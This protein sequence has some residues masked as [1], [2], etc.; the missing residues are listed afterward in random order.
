LRPGLW[1]LAHE[2]RQSRRH[3]AFPRLIDGKPYITAES[4]KIHFVSELSQVSGPSGIVSRGQ[5]S[6]GPGGSSGPMNYRLDRCFKVAAM[7]FQGKLE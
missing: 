5:A 1:R 2:S 3:I 6:G 4:G 7:N